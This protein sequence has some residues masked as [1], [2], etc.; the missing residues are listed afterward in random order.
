MGTGL[1][2][3]KDFVEKTGERQIKS[4]VS[5]ADAEKMKEDLEKIGCVIL[6]K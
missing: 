6:I 1:K 5:K 3:T 2:E 4:G